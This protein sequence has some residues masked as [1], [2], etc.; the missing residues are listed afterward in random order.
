MVATVYGPE[1]VTATP[2]GRI[3]GWPNAAGRY[4]RIPDDEYRGPEYIGL[5]PKLRAGME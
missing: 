5:L 4:E 3:E 2:F 1:R